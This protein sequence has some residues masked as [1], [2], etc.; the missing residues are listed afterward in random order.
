MTLP[1]VNED[2]VIQWFSEGRPY[3]WMA[4]EYERKYNT[5][6]TVTMWGN[7][8]RRNNLPKVLITLS[9]RSM[10]W[11]IREEH[12][13]CYPAMMLRTAAMTV[14]Q[15]TT[16]AREAATQFHL[17]DLNMLRLRVWRD[18]LAADGLV[19]HYEPAAGFSYVARRPGI[20]LGLVREPE[21]SA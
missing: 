18:L 2:E 8:R 3:A 10:P 7:Y 16:A 17:S 5:D 19:V 6:T 13:L 15:P 11:T 1:I 9:N 12:L 14:E 20:D 4:Q 21:E